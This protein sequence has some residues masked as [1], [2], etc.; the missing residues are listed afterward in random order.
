M[1]FENHTLAPHPADAICPK[2]GFEA[3]NIYQGGR[4]RNYWCSVEECDFQTYRHPCPDCGLYFGRLNRETDRIAPCPP[5]ANARDRET[6]RAA[7]I[8]AAIAWHTNMR[9]ESDQSGEYH[10]WP[11]E[12]D[13]EALTDAVIAYEDLILAKKDPQR[14]Y[15]ETVSG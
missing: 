6:A 10:S 14:H 9:Q 11:R 8:H 3:M 5:C 2:H 15:E 12:E 13:E 1:K 4:H 7:I